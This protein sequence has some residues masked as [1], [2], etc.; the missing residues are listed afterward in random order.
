MNKAI[1][2]GLIGMIIASLS[3]TALAQIDL[4]HPH[5]STADKVRDVTSKP[6]E[7]I[8]LMS[9][10]EGMTVLDLLGGSGYFS[11]LLSQQLGA[12]GKVLLHNNKAYM[13]FVGKDLEARLADGS[14][15]NVV[16]YDR[17]V[18]QLGLAENSLDAVFFVMGYHDMYHVSPGWKIDDKDLM[19]QIKKALKPNGLMLVIDHAAPIGSKLAQAQDNHRIDEEFVK[20]SLK[21]FGFEIVKQSDL[22]RNPADTRTNLVFDPAIRG[23]TDRFVF[24]VKNMKE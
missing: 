17:E 21:G 5:R 14:L 15:K 24:V 20:T 18:D 7:T 10:Q 2:L 12:K 16:R 1:R 9:I 8:A 6:L 13:P 4:N 23:K 3:T 19:G 22:L 11:E